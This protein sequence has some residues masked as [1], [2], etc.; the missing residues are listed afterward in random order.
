MESLAVQRGI[1]SPRTIVIVDDFVTKG[2]SLLAAATR[3]QE[4]FPEAEVLGF[5]LIRTLGLVP[6]IEKILSPCTGRIWHDGR[7]VRREP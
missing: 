3:I 1:L 5:A 4:A 2:A 7:D 6:E